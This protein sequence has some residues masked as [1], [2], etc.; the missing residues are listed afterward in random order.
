MP[1]IVSIDTTDFKVNAA[2]SHFG[3][4][5]RWLPCNAHCRSAYMFLFACAIRIFRMHDKCFGLSL[6]HT[7]TPTTL[8]HTTRH[9]KYCFWTANFSGCL[10]PAY[11]STFADY[12]R[13]MGFF[14]PWCFTRDIR[15]D[16]KNSFSVQVFFDILFCHFSLAACFFISFRFHSYH[17]ECQSG[18]WH[19]NGS[20][21][22]SIALIL[23]NVH[24]TLCRENRTE[25]FYYILHEL[26]RYFCQCENGT[27]WVNIFGW[28]IGWSF[29][30]YSYRGSWFNLNDVLYFRSIRLHIKF[31]NKFSKN[32]SGWLGSG[33]RVST[34]DHTNK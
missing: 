30:R 17:L 26:L 32:V 4:R 7:H 6:T 3:K 23:F 21:G 22:A 12:I 25:N 1:H 29:G 31:G 20:R 34:L 18:V 16:K 13:R 5:R 33:P 19:L 9:T 2:R 10:Q 11:S 27:E 8:Q 14:P 15:M 28:S 24:S